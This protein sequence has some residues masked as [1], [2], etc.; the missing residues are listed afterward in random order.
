MVFNVE[1]TM[2]AIE[3][4]LRAGGWVTTVYQGE[5]EF[6]P[7]HDGVSAAIFMDS[8]AVL[9]AKLAGSI[10][11]QTIIVR[12][13]A[14]EAERPAAGRENQLDAAYSYLEKNL[15]SDLDL[16]ATVR[17]VQPVQLAA[18]WGYLDHSGTRYRIVE[19][20]VPVVVDDS[21][22]PAP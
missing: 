11:S 4:H 17:N 13:Y 21:A 9:A 10:E 2:V 16:G 18:D 22:T 19:V 5:P 14:V 20:A 1:P 15:L 12:L 6:P 8:V 3:G 7:P